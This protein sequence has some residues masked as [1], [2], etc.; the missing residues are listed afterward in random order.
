MK[1]LV[2]YGHIP[3]MGIRINL[4]IRKSRQFFLYFMGFKV[5]IITAMA[6]IY[7]LP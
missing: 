1:A 7:T 3:T 4:I 6:S 2:E 5:Q